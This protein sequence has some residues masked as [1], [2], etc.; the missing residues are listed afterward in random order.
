MRHIECAQGSLEWF[1]ARAGIP[2]ASEFDKILTPKTLRPSAQAEQYLHRLLAEWMTGQVFETE[3]RV[4]AMDRGIE[5]EAEALEFY[6]LTTQEVTSP[7]GF[8]LS[9]E[10][11]YGA[12]PD[13]FAGADGLL[14][15]KCPL[16]STHVGYLL[17]GEV[18]SEYLIQLQGQLL[19][20]GRRWVDVLVY[21]PGLPP[22]LLRMEPDHEIREAL[23]EALAGFC[24]RL[25]DGKRRLEA[26]RKG[27]V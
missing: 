13:R 15:I 1:R 19:V 5:L 18:P 10:G 23:I 8:C 6:E 4:Y 21:Y 2:T 26:L 9:D 24:L 7:A 22:L 12:S 3:T 11:T 16:A 17:R 20:T 14:E 27:N 25:E